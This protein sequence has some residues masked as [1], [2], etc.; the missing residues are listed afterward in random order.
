MIKRTFFSIIIA[1]VLWGCDVVTDNDRLTVVPFD[2]KKPV[3]IMDFTGWNCTNCPNA[4]RTI[5]NM[6]EFDFVSDKIIAVA[7]HPEGIHWTEPEGDAIDLRSEAATEYWKYF[8]SPQAFPV[9]S[10]DFVEYNNSLLIPE[11]NWNSAVAQRI[12]MDVPLEIEINCNISTTT[13]KVEIIST[14]TSTADTNDSYSLIL[15]ITEN[16]VIG[17]QL[18][19]GVYIQNYRHNHVLRS[20]INGIWGE[21]ISFSGNNC[22]KTQTCNL[23]PTWN[24]QNCAIVGIIINSNTKEAV[25]SCEKAL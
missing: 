16:N 7:M 23:N 22:V 18:D 1:T 13:G 4:A 11:K 2:V 3:V 20:A 6:R 14:I 5:Q 24:I 9:G 15:W 12:A 10:V 21:T 17:L 25:V 19:N 8:G